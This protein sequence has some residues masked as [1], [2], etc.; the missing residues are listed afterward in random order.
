VVAG[1]VLVVALGKG[2]AVPL[3]VPIAPMLV[4][5]ATYLVVVMIGGNGFVAAFVCGVGFGAATRRAARTASTAP[6]RD[7][8]EMLEFSHRTSAL[9]GYAVW[10]VF[11]ESVLG[12]LTTAHLATSVVYA[13]L[14]LTVLRMLPVAVAAIGLHLPRDTVL[15]VGWLG[16]R[17]LASIIFGIL[18]ADTIGG[19]PGELV[20][21]VVA[22]TVAMSV[23]AHGLSAGPLA[24]WFSTRHP[25]GAEPRGDQ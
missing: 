6:E 12:S 19:E 7:D 24:T 8:D 18:A 22:V 3:L 2:W 20:L 11:G 10:F 13:V 23:L 25:A 16:P 14:S 15:L 1:R 17:G 9:L 21:T 4:A 5:V